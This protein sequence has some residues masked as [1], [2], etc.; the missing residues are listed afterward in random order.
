MYSN[1]EFDIRKV[2]R[3]NNYLKRL[4]SGPF[5]NRKNMLELIVLIELAP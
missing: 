3:M 2:R 4:F 1:E 5:A